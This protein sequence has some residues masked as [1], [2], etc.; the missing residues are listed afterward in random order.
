MPEAEGWGQLL[1]RT[2]KA[3]RIPNLTILVNQSQKK[4]NT[5]YGGKGSLKYHIRKWYLTVEHVHL[6]MQMQGRT[7]LDRSTNIVELKEI[8]DYIIMHNFM[9]FVCLLLHF[10]NVFWVFLFFFGGGA[11]FLW[12]VGS[13]YW[14]VDNLIIKV[15]FNLFCLFLKEKWVGF[16]RTAD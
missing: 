13:S 6:F 8:K 7:T 1:R 16:I 5:H 4:K 9:R 11:L 14:G 12:T 3:R 2:C 10:V 15:Q